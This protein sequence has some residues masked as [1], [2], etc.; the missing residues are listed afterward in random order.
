MYKPLQIVHSLQSSTES[1]HYSYPLFN[2]STGEIIRPESLGQNIRLRASCDY[3]RANF[4][5]ITDDKIEEGDLYF[6]GVG[7][8]HKASVVTTIKQ[9]GGGK[10]V[11]YHEGGN[12]PFDFARVEDCR[13]IVASTDLSLICP[14][15][16]YSIFDTLKSI[17]PNGEVNMISVRHDAAVDG[18]DPKS[19]T[20]IT[21]P[22]GV[23]VSGEGFIDLKLIDPDSYTYAE[24]ILI[25][26]HSLNAGAAYEHS[27]KKIPKFDKIIKTALG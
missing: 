9:L 8:V 15:I 25:I 17:K 23:Y 20:H 6:S 18:W 3:H 26:E 16:P 22:E 11:I 7:R 2:P 24:V 5:I 10:P 4:H 19:K 21:L 27:G 13:K 14:T 12:G 1:Q